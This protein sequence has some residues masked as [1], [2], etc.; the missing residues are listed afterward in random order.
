VPDILQ[1]FYGLVQINYDFKKQT[2]IL[3]NKHRIIFLQT[4]K[5]FVK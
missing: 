5:G 1:R 3:I 4:K 2:I